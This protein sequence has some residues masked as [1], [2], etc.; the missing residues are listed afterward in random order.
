MAK[1]YTITEY[2]FDP[3]VEYNTPAEGSVASVEEMLKLPWIKHFRKN[4]EF[5]RFSVS[6]NHEKFNYLMIENSTCSWWWIVALI[7]KN[8]NECDSLSKQNLI[9]P[10][11]LSGD[12]TPVISSKDNDLS[13]R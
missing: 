7:P 4:K 6:Q 5:S 1:K 3:D 10:T 11:I 9:H 2:L 8:F 13:K 12:V